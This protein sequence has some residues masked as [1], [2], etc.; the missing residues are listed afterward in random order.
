MISG[1]YYFIVC[2]GREPEKTRDWL[3]KELAKYRESR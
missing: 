1:Q 3:L 2:P